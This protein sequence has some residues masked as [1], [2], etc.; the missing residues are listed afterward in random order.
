MEAV[1]VLLALVLAIQSASAPP[2]DIHWMGRAIE[3]E[4]LDWG[5]DCP[6]YNRCG[7]MIAHVALNRKRSPRFPGVMRNVVRQGF[8]GYVLVEEPS[9]RSLLLASL[10]KWEYYYVPHDRS[11]GSIF[12]FSMLD[13]QYE[14]PGVPP[15][16]ASEVC[17]CY[18]ARIFYFWRGWPTY[19]VR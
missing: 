3:G 8:N 13:M 19:E 11:N 1:K 14:F 7:I 2:P 5:R 4:M 17:Q 18:G 15:E 9:Y 16:N 12:M 10:A 6:E